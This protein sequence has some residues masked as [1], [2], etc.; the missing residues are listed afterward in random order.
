MRGRI[1]NPSSIT[2]EQIG[3]IQERFGSALLDLGLQQES[4]EEIIRSYWGPKLID[5]LIMVVSDRVELSD[6]LIL[7]HA[8]VDRSRNPNEVFGKGHVVSEVAATMPGAGSGIEEVKVC[9]FWIGR[10]I[11]DYD[12]EKKYRRY[13]LNPVDPYVLAAV[14]EQDS[15]FPK[16]YRNATHWKDTNGRWCY[17]YYQNQRVLVGNVPGFPYGKCWFAGTEISPGS[18]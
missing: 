12:L 2:S 1:I 9:F 8:R 14:N 10:I 17:A 5:D 16:K 15:I 3:I 4:I 7:I 6:Y 13:G 11:N 18:D